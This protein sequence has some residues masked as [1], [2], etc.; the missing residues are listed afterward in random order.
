MAYENHPLPPVEG[1]VIEE[2]YFEPEET[3]TFDGG[4]ENSKWAIEED[5][6][7]KAGK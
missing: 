6:E 3:E 1:E 4:I 5:T 7:P 2:L